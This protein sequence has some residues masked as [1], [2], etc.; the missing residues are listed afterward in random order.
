MAFKLNSG[1]VVVSMSDLTRHPWYDKYKDK[2]NGI[3]A[4]LFTM[5]MDIKLPFTCKNI[6]HRSDMTN[7][8][9]TC[10]RFV[11]SK[12]SDDSWVNIE[13]QIGA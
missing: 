13:R 9:V 6:T 12:R 1:N 7:H 4:L 3:P 2:E 11:G 10:E 8:V 5:G